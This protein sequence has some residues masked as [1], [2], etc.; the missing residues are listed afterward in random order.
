ML[1]E[2]QN[3]TKEELVNE[4]YDSRVRG[5]ADYDDEDVHGH[6]K[7]IPYIGWFWRSTDFVN[8]R[9]SIGNCGS[10]IGVMEYNKWGY[11]KRDMT[12][13]EVD[14]FIE[15]LER[16]F[17]HDSDVEVVSNE[18]WDWFQTLRDVGDWG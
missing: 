16:I 12:E 8:K 5:V 14:V 7:R 13:Q 9:V 18:M 17:K 11:P 15:Y 2:L 10:F 1:E 3:K 6:C 4:L